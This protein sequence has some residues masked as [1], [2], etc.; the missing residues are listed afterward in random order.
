MNMQARQGR[1]DSVRHGEGG[2]GGPKKTKTEQRIGEREELHTGSYILMSAR[3]QSKQ[4]LKIKTVRVYFEVPYKRKS[5]TGK[6]KK[7]DKEKE[8][9]RGKRESGGGGDRTA[10]TGGIEKCLNNHTQ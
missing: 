1:A 4:K 2:G 9:K 5:E 3:V 6:I 7:W 8:K 10:G